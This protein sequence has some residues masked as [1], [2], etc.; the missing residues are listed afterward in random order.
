MIYEMRTDTFATG[1]NAK[2]FVIKFG[3]AI[4]HRN[5]FSRL[6]A[7]WITEIGPL[8]PNPPKEGVWLAS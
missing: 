4:E 7:L 1:A 3:E 5:T 6:G 2:D 8:S